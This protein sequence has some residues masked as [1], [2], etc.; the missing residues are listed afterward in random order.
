[1]ILQSA[2]AVATGGMPVV[3]VVTVAFGRH[4]GLQGLHEMEGPHGLPVTEVM[5][6]VSVSVSVSAP[7]AVV[8]SSGELWVGVG[9][10][11]GSPGE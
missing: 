1:M 6:S 2:P 3:V 9:V 10:P 7:V 4:D 11:L 8:I 5:V